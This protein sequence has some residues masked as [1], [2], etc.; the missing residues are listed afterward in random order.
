V[1]LQAGYH[2]IKMKPEDVFKT[3][4]RTHVGHYELKV[5][6]FRLTNAPTTFQA[7]M[8]QVFLPQLRKFVLVFFDDILV[9]SRFRADHCMQRDI[10]ALGQSQVKYLGHIITSEGVSTDPSKVQSMSEWPTPTTLR[11]LRGILGLRAIIENMWNDKD[12]QAFIAWK[13]AMPTAHVLALPDYTKE[14]IVETDASLTRIG[15]VLTQ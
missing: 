4:F 13:H 6:P 11:A 12:D 10:N 15:V 5:M 8:N 2:Q 3:A 14:F 1:N 9:Y 7:L